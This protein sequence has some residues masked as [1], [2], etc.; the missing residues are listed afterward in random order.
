[1]RSS[2]ADRRPNRNDWGGNPR[3]MITRRGV[4]FQCRG[5][6]LLPLLPLLLALLLLPRSARMIYEAAHGEFLVGLHKSL[7]SECPVP[8]GHRHLPMGKLKCDSSHSDDLGFSRFD[9][10]QLEG[11]ALL[12][13]AVACCHL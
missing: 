3:Q 12:G 6:M 4:W 10:G 7:R 1:M 13:Q 9:L 5:A 8:Q 11:S 2:T